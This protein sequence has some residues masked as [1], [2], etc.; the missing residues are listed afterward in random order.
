MSVV[1]KITQLNF[2][3]HRTA[4]NCNLEELS[5]LRLEWIFP[6]T[7]HVRDIAEMSLDFM[8]AVRA[9]R[10]PHL[11][12][13]RVNLRIGMNTGQH[14]HFPFLISIVFQSLEAINYRSLCGRSGRSDDAS[15][16]S[17]RRYGEHRI[18]N[19]KQWKSEQ[20]VAILTSLFLFI[21]NYK[22]C[23]PGLIHM[24]AEANKLL[25]TAYNGQY[26]TQSRGDVIIKVRLVQMHCVW[27]IWKKWNYLRSTYVFRHVLFMHFA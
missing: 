6:G 9:Y 11:P 2:T 15:L 10:V 14:F 4:I 22:Y 13:E 7:E 18:E 25:I 27:W 12:A 26:T 1:Q 23:Q 17:L 24:S 20:L 21:V 16:L 3:C 19:G 8:S 5:L